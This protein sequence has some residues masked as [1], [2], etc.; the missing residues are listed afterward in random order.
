MHYSGENDI[1]YASIRLQKPEEK[2]HTAL[3]EMIVKSG[4]DPI[5]A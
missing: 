5:F 4:V 1:I 2:L 3:V